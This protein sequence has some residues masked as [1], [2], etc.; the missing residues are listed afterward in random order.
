MFIDSLTEEV[1][2][3]DSLYQ[4]KLYLVARRLRLYA[5][6]TKLPLGNLESGYNDYCCWQIKGERVAA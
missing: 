5:T 2:A 3:G 1:I 6:E 4:I